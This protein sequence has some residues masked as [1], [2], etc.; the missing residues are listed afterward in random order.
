MSLSGERKGSSGGGRRRVRAGGKKVGVCAKVRSENE[1]G[2][3]D[4]ACEGRGRARAETEEREG[5]SERAKERGQEVGVVWRRK[6][7]SARGETRAGCPLPWRGHPPQSTA[8]DK[9]APDSAPQREKGYIASLK[10]GE[11]G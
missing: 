8:R 10:V 2:E 5:E 4:E 6:G 7:N 11:I 3:P 1:C 9:P